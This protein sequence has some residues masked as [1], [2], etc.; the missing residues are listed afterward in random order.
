MTI[1]VWNLMYAL[2]NTDRVT[3]DSGNPQSRKASLE[4]AQV[5]TQNGWRC[6]VEHHTSAKRIYENPL[7]EA[8]R[9][10]PEQKRVIK[11]AEDN[12]LGYATSH[13]RKR[14]C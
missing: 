13:S 6:W 11:F 3:G 12:V 2:G 7:E 10:D 8:H 14:Q 9:V 4:G 1:T 5:I